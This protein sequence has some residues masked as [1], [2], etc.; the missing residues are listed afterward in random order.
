M[1]SVL[2]KYQ[3]PV[4]LRVTIPLSAMLP[5]LIARV[6]SCPKEP[7]GIENVEITTSKIGEYDFASYELEIIV[8]AN[9]FVLRKENLE[10]CTKSILDGVNKYFME[11]IKCSQ[12][13]TLVWVRLFPGCFLGT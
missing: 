9:E 1:V 5:T 2:I 6:L 3:H 11:E 7:L 4:S 8:E 10:N 13:K 12:P